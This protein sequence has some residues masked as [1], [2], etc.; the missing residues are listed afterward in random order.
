MKQRIND[1]INEDIKL[2]EM[3][4]VV[5]EYLVHS[6]YQETFMALEDQNGYTDGKIIVDVDIEEQ[7]KK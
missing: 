5:R 4:Y 7:M 6:G 2:S 1:V 3:D